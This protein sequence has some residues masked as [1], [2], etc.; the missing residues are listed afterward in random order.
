MIWCKTVSIQAAPARLPDGSDRAGRLSFEELILA[1]K[2]NVEEYDELILDGDPDGCGALQ[3]AMRRTYENALQDELV[4]ACHENGV[5][6]PAYCSERQGTIDAMMEIS[7]AR[8]S[9]GF[10]LACWL[11]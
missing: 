4:A 1:W 3:D 2:V 5:A 6:A 9:D 8:M 11:A 10:V 7:T